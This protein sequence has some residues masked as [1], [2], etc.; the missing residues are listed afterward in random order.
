MIGGKPYGDRT[1]L[2]KGGY[3]LTLDPSL[4][5]M[6]NTDVLIEGDNIA[7]VG[8]GLQAGPHANVIDARHRIVMPGFVDTH[9]HTWQSIVRN[10][11]SDWTLIDYLVG[12]HSGLSKHFRPQDTYIGNLAA[13]SK[14]PQPV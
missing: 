10:I 2:I 11:A 6:A 7:A 12:L 4:G 8:R 5:D 9:R 3:V 14:V 13:L 1:T